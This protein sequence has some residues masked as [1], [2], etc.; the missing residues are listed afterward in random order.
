MC[1]G[2]SYFLVAIIMRVVL[3]I[4][5]FYP[6]TEKGNLKEKGFNVA[7]SSRAQ[8]TVAVSYCSIKLETETPK[9]YDFQE[10]FPS[11]P[12]R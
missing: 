4:R 9:I 2:Y 1:C 5:I 10:Q 11:E 7:Y 12:V 6:R 8:S 3:F